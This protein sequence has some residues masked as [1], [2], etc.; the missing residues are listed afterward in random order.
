MNAV[1]EACAHC[2]DI[3]LAPKNSTEMSKPNNC[4]VDNVSYGTLLKVIN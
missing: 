2:G 1:L 3:D 4:G